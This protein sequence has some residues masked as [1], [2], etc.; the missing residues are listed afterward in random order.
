MKLLSEATFEWMTEPEPTFGEGEY[1]RPVR[2]MINS[3]KIT[4]ASEKEPT[5]R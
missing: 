2:I 4:Y 3:A 1:P 5:I